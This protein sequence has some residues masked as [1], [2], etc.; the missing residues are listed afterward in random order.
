VERMQRLE[1]TQERQ[2]RERKWEPRRATRY[3]THYGS[4]EEEEDWKVKFFEVRRH[5]QHQQ[6]KSIP[7]VKLPSFNGDSDPNIYLGYKAKVEQIFNVY[8]VEDDQKVKLASLEFEDY[9]MQW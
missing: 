6:K 9:A 3:H 1:D 8:E 5:Q 7:F 4:Q 2:N